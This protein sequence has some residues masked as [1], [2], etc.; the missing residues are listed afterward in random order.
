MTASRQR[1]DVAADTTG[2]VSAPASGRARLRGLLAGAVTLVLAACVAEPDAVQ[3]RAA[4]G[5]SADRALEEFIIVG[6]TADF[7]GDNCGAYGIR[8]RFAN[9]DSLI[10][11][12]IGNLV[13][14]GY[15]P[16]ELAAAADRISEQ[17]IAE[18]TLDRLKAR[19]ARRGDPGSVCEVGLREIKQGTTIG[20]L[21]EV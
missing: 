11:G 6:A 13:S 8:K 7:I 18:K 21:L 4:P 19:G 10:R 2:A 14:Q 12:Y 17:E 20:R 15:S 1:P 9:S 3:V 5:A 16:T